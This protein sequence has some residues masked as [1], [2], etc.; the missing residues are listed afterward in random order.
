MLG[1]THLIAKR[2]FVSAGVKHLSQKVGTVDQV[3]G[4][5]GEQFVKGRFNWPDAKPHD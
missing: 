1:F 5:L 3:I 2:F 4:H